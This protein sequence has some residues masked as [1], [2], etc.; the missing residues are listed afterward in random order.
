MPMQLAE[1]V[2]RSKVQ[3]GGMVAWVWLRRRSGPPTSCGQ[4]SMAFK[5]TF[6]WKTQQNIYR[7]NQHSRRTKYPANLA[8]KKNDRPA[9]R[10][11]PPVRG[12]KC[13]L[14]QG[15]QSARFLSEKSPS[16]KI[17]TKNRVRRGFESQPTREFEICSFFVLFFFCWGCFF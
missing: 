5:V 16:S 2:G 8:K 15:P 6:L 11:R 1:T 17:I 12:R 9:L 7:T 4:F 10:R 3:S 14:E 13:L